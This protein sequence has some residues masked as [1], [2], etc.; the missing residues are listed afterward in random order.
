MN[1]TDRDR[2]AAGMRAGLP[3][4]LGY[5]PAAFAFGAAA[6]AIGLSAPEV[7]AMSAIVFSGANQAFLLAAIPA[8]M[9]VVLMVALTAAASLRHLLYGLVLRD[10]IGGSRP[11]RAAFAYGLTDEVFATALAAS[12]GDHGKARPGGRWLI[13]L[14][15]TA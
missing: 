14:A 5:L 12:T 8:G 9:P 2:I 6:S 15:L 1:G 3:V 11:Q 7:G 10:R 13:G 4:A